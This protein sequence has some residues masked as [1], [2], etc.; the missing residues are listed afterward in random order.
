LSDKQFFRI[1]QTYLVNLK[2]IKKYSKNNGGEVILKNGLTLP[3]SRRKKDELLLQLS[4]M[5]I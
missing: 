5:S 4:R 2:F 1:H 3:V